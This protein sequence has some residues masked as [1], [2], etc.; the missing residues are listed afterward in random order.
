MKK[1]RILLFLLVL[2]SCNRY[3]GT[4]DPD[5]TPSN[6]ITEIFSNIQIE[7]NDLKFNLGEVIY[8][9]KINPLL[10]KSNY[11]IDKIINTD[12]KSAINFFNKKIFLSKGENIFVIDIDNN[13]NNYNI[14]LDLKSDEYVIHFF[15]YENNIYLITNISRLF[16]LESENIS[17]VN[18]YG[19]YTTTLPIINYNNLIIF[20]VFGDIYQI[21]LSDNS[22]FK[23]G[24][25]KP[26]HG[27]SINSNTFVDKSNIY[28][29]FNTGTLITLDKNENELFDNYILEDLNILTSLGFFNELIDTPFNFNDYLYFLDRS[30]KI[31]VYNPISS[32]IL[33]EFD[34][35]STI[36][37]YLF[38]NDGHLII[39]TSDKILVFSYKGKLIS[40]YT[41]NK[42]SPILIFS[43]QGNIYLISKEGI[44]SINFDKKTENIF[45]KNKFTS[46]IDIYYQNQNIFLKDDKS[47][48]K[49]SE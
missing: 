15:E 29:L 34:T 16:L 3:M 37:H 1:I 35:N 8:P 41:H 22:I 17:E 24:D 12:E 18:D 33:W 2:S 28:H 49:L 48:F 7:S 40:T 26:R 13:D 19:I 45:I 38:T 21:N 14:K 10:N 46:N 27:I 43:V 6:E 31:S 39:L 42:E 32:E 47:L 5:Y 30:G 44:V 20:D 9:K 23:K 4:I 11:E 25:I 36:I